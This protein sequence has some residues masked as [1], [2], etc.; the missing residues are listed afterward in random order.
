MADAAAFTDDVLQVIRYRSYLPGAPPPPAPM[1]QPQFPL[2]AALAHVTPRPGPDMP[3]PT[4]LYH[5]SAPYST[6][7]A[8][9]S[10]SQAQGGS[11]KRSYSDRD[12]NDVDIILTSRSPYG[13]PYKQARRGGGFSQRGGRYEDAYGSRSNRAPP[14]YPGPPAPVSYGTPLPFA[15]APIDANSIIE[16]I[17]ILQSLL[18]PAVDLP[19]PVYSGAAVPPG[20]RRKQRCRDYDTKGYCSRGSNC[21][22]E[23][24]TRPSYIPPPRSV[25]V[26]GK[27]P[28]LDNTGPGQHHEN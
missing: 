11:H 17:Q 12:D 2:P 4:S 6:P 19:K 24:G 3:P 27:L 23:H 25:V 18:P 16:N 7:L 9:P 15:P 21:N 1:R 5:P 14:F 26:D 20:R 13:Q 28:L 8:Q 10:F 22:F